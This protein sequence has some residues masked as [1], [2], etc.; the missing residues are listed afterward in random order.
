MENIEEIRKQVREKMVGTNKAIGEEFLKSLV[1][2]ETKKRIHALM[3]LKNRYD[4]KQNTLE[5]LQKEGLKEY[6]SIGNVIE[7][8]FVFNQVQAKKVKELKDEMD[9][10][11]SVINEYINNDNYK[12]LLKLSHKVLLLL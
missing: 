6:D 10:I 12:V 1:I 9:E 8:K 2:E 4:N 5:D 3:A 7:G 11:N